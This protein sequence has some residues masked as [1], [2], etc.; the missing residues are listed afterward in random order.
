MN[1][2]RRQAIGF[3]AGAIAFVATGMPARASMEA[4]DAAI[5]AFAGDAAVGEGKITLTTPEIA[6]NG[7]TV[8]IS[9][10]VD[11]PMTADDHVTSVAIYADGNPSPEVIAFNFTPAGGVAAAKTRIR[12]A[13]TQHVVAVA[14]M[15]DGSVVMAKNEVKVTIGGCGG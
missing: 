6:E 4:T 14:K 13:K 7:N 12:L 1:L 8:P 9:V 5:K 11:S 3:G 15:S 10:E 2:T